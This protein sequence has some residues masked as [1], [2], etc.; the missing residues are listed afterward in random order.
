MIASNGDATA[1][2]RGGQPASCAEL[3][4]LKSVGVKSILKLNDRGLPVDSDEKDQAENLGLRMLSLPFGAAT[5][6]RPATCDSVRQALSFL[7]DPDNWPVY[8]HCTAGKDRTGYT[9]GMYE[10]LRL[11]KPVEAVMKELHRYGHR[12]WRSLLFPQIDHEL[13]AGHPVCE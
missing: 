10:K 1:I 13:A 2:Y 5:I 7:S 11:G 3:A 12:G 8:V 6:G 9:V 4:Y